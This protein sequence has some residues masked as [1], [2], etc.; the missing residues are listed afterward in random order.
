M[1]EGLDIIEES[2]TA[3]GQLYGEIKGAQTAVQLNDGHYVN[4]KTGAES[5]SG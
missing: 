1:V 5:N 3:L 2:I 4:K